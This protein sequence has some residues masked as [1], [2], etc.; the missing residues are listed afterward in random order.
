MA[1]NATYDMSNSAGV[2]GFVT[3]AEGSNAGST[4]F[5]IGIDRLEKD[6]KSEFFIL[7]NHF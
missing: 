2:N 1:H 6:L 4:F 3:V 5:R 7:F